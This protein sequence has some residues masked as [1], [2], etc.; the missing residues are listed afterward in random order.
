MRGCRVNCSWGAIAMGVRWVTGTE[1]R[2]ETPSGCRKYLEEKCKRERP[3][4][5]MRLI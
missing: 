5:T 1:T 4:E 3:T 2:F